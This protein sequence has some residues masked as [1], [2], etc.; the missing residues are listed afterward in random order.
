M[1][2]GIVS[3]FSVQ[4]K[5]TNVM[6]PTGLQRNVLQIGGIRDHCIQDVFEHFSVDFAV[7]GFGGSAGPSDVEEM[8]NVLK[9]AEFGEGFFG[10]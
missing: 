7:L 10:I 1:K 8:G 2:R 3:D 9:T 5:R 6:F 4:F